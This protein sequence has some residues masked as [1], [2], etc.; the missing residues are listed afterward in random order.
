MPAALVVD[1]VPRTLPN[2]S[3]KTLMETSPSDPAELAETGMLGGK[4]GTL[5]VAEDGEY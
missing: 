4:R 1:Q 3:I 2:L 5:M